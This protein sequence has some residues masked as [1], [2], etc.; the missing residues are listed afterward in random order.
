M[1]SELSALTVHVQCRDKVLLLI[2]DYGVLPARVDTFWLQTR[3]SLIT[4]AD[5]LAKGLLR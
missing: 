1:V 2:T 4:P 3:P 5:G